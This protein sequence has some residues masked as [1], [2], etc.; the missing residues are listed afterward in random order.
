MH[1]LDFSA[2]RQLRA[3]SQLTQQQ[4]ADKLGFNRE[5]LSAIECNKQTPGF[6]TFL[7][8]AEFFGLQAWELMRK[9]TIDDAQTEK[10]GRGD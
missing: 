5:F 9:V 1:R 10:S 7:E 6:K 3:Y 2:L 4:V 8:L